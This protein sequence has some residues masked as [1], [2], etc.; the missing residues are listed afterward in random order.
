VDKAG[1]IFAAGSP[2]ADVSIVTRPVEICILG[3]NA[4][5]I[6]LIAWLLRRSALQFRRYQP[7][8]DAPRG[9]TQPGERDDSAS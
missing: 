6:E 4:A 1:S 5:T 7:G 9:T 8:A 3:N 2:F